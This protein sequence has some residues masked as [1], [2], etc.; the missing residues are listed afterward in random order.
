M[1][2]VLSGSMEKTKSAAATT[3]TA[4]SSSFVKPA[5]PLPS[6]EQLKINRVRRISASDPAA[7]VVSGVVSPGLGPPS[8]IRGGNRQV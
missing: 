4:I 7:G 6:R 1:I 2:T 3:P 5:P 8:T